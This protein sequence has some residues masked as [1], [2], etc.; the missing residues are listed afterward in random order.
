[1]KQGSDLAHQPGLGSGL[2]FGQRLSLFYG[3]LFVIY[4]MHVPYMPVWLDGRGL[5]AAEISTVIAA[6][7]FIRVLITP[8]VA[9]AADRSGRHRGM[10]IALAWLAAVL[11]VLLSRMH[12]FWPIFLFAVPLSIA[13]STMMPLTETIAVSGVRHAG[14]DYGRMRLWGSLTFVA[15]SFAGGWAIERYGAS[16]GIYLIAFGCAATL[17]VAHL[18]PKQKLGNDEHHPAAAPWWK[19]DEPMQLLANPTFIAFLVAAGGTQAAHATFMTFGALIWQK[20]DLTG[21]WIGTLWAIGVFA[22]VTLFAMSGPLVRRFGPARLLLV[23]AAA[24]VVRWLAMAFNPS[25]AALLPLQILHGFTYGA[26]HIGAIHFIGRA[27]PV[28]A[29]GTAQALYATVAA[30]VAMGLATLVAGKLYAS[31]GAQSYAAM[32]LLAVVALVAAIRL[33]SVWRGEALLPEK[34]TPKP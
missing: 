25:L 20:Q 2:G 31:I 28:R 12:G 6:P 21:A 29:V 34:E 32:A 11:V 1:M 33:D 19:A 16:A 9:L 27:V 18:L 13:Y 5:S 7:L 10:V 4:G 3:A 26:T 30:G 23:G 15:A 17:A 22:E 14:L 8:A 24:S